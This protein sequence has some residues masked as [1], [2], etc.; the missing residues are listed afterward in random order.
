MGLLLGK[1]KNGRK[2]GQNTSPMIKKK[3]A[4]VGQKYGSQKT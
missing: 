1:M 3:G 4:Y 2:H